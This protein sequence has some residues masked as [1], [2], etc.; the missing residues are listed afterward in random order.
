MALNNLNNINWTLVSAIAMIILPISIIAPVII[1]LIQEWLSN[2]KD[3]K[4][5]IHKQSVKVHRQKHI[6]NRQLKKVRI[7]KKGSK[8]KYG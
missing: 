5:T 1:I 2:R 3:C 4:D 7:K 6:D 8:R